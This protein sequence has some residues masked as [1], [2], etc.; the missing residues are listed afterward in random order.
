MWKFKNDKTASVITAKKHIESCHSS[1]D[2]KELPKTAVLFYMRGGEKFACENYDTVKLSDRF[3]RFLN[4][5]PVYEFANCDVC[6]LDGGRGAPQ[7]ADTIETLHALGVENVVTVG[8]FGAFS[9]GVELGDI[10][11]PCKA[12]VE[13]GTSLHYY[14]EINFSQP[15]LKFKTEAL[16]FLKG[17]KSLPIVSTD[18]VYRQTFFKEELWRKQG[19]AGVDM[20][21]SALFSVGSYLNMRVVSILIA[22]D[23]HPVSE[24]ETPWKWSMSAES[25]CSF[26]E[27]CIGLSHKIAKSV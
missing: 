23:K 26:F 6:F 7:A 24:K 25:R 21:T 5:C 3:P 15:D 4:A 27:K 1:F 10:V 17:S 20:E 18:A 13:E 2:I 11:V 19:A 16:E 8:M 9:D 14:D 22:S 12:F